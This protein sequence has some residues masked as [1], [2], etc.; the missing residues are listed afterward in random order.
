MPLS[1][2]RRPRSLRSSSMAPAPLVGC[3]GMLASA[4]GRLPF[5][6]VELQGIR[7]R[8][9]LPELPTTAESVGKQPVLPNQLSNS[10]KE[11]L[12]VPVQQVLQKDRRDGHS[13]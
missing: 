11:G 6:C 3:S 8:L 13:K 9:G 4:L 7:K 2:E 1:R 5:Q 10:G 12:K